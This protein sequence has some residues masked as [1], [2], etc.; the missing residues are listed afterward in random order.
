[1]LIKNRN[2]FRISRFIL[3]KLPLLFRFLAKFRSPQKRL[4]II[5]TDAIGDYILFR[6]FLEVVR[7]SEAYKDYKIHLLG[8]VLWSDLALK[9]DS[10]F[11]DEFIFT[12]PN[13]LYESPL[14]LFKLGWRIFKNNYETV[15][16]PSSTRT[17][18]IDGL[19]GLSA[20]KNIIGFESNNEGIDQKYKTKTD[21]FYTRLLPL[22]PTVYF[23]FDRTKYFFENVLDQKLAINNIS[24]DFEAKDNKGIVIFPGAGVFKRGWEREKL[25]EL[26]KLITQNSSQQ[27][28]LSGGPAEA[29]IGQYLTNNLAEKSVVNLIGKSTLPQLVELIGNV[30]L[31]IANETSAIHIAAATK[32]QSVCILGGGHFGRFAPY[33]EYFENRPVCV[34]YQMECY[35]CNWDCIYKAK[36]TEPYPCISNVSLNSVWEAILPL[37]NA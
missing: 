9:Y 10:R 4:L 5:K 26:I 32:T 1:M 24:I 18:I 13:D 28:Y 11:T 37:L 35:Y 15:L 36:E 31:V 30:S 27:I 34:H 8:N 12:K 6:N 2:L 33:P 19:A 23:E 20:A 3:L 14:K 22:P 29:A 25:L 7:S 21:K 17:F 16:Q